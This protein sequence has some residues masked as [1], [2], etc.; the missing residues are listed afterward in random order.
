M[1][2]CDAGFGVGCA[3][4]GLDVGRRDVG[5]GVVGCAVV[6]SVLLD[7]RVGLEVGVLVL[8]LGVG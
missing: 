7:W 4:N 8:G 1:G 3:V 6:G 2:R 5:L